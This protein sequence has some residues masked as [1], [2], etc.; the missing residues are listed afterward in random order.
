[1]EQRTYQGKYCV[2]CKGEE[3]TA[4]PSKADE[5]KKSKK[6]KGKSKKAKD[7]L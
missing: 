1:L 6:K 7:E 3:P 2:E 4:K 5:K